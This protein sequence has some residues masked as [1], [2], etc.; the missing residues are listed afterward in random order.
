MIKLLEL[1]VLSFK[2]ARVLTG[3]CPPLSGVA[4]AGLCPAGVQSFYCPLEELQEA[5]SLPRLS[6]AHDFT[7]WPQTF[8]DLYLN[9]SKSQQQLQPHSCSCS[10]MERTMRLCPSVSLL[11]AKVFTIYTNNWPLTRRSTVDKCLSSNRMLC[12]SKLRKWK[13]L[14]LYN[15]YI[16]SIFQFSVLF[17]LKH[18]KICFNTDIINCFCFK[19][20]IFGGASLT[21]TQASVLDQIFTITALNGLH[22]RICHHFALKITCM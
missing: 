22:P 14:C 13:I 20:N 15:F 12:Y 6:S 3:C 9:S 17:L 10:M 8:Q 11:T 7:P 19:R 18:K 5:S 2:G 4:G 1:F 21:W 16:W